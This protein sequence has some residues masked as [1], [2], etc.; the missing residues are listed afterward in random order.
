MFSS[1]VSFKNEKAVSFGN[2]VSDTNG[3]ILSN[4]NAFETDDDGFNKARVKLINSMRAPKKL[5]K[6]YHQMGTN[7]MRQF[8][9]L[10]EKASKSM[11]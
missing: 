2:I 11:Q 5:I 10:L 7:K 3:Q 8:Y 9:H 1:N 4:M 6:K